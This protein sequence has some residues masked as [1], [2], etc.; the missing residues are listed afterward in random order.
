MIT[1]SY[2]FITPS[3]IQKKR[4]ENSQIIMFNPKKKKKKYDF[5]DFYVFFY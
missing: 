1:S 3:L 2:T 5:R 4:G